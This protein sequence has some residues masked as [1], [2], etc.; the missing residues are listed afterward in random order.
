MI[1]ILLFNIN[2]KEC[3]KSEVLSLKY[4]CMLVMVWLGTEGQWTTN[5]FW[6][7]FIDLGAVKKKS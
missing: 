2:K 6:A 5:L 7:I 1:I 3:K 4:V